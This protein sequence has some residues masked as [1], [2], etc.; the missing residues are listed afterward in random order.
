MI[1]ITGGAGFIGSHL[2]DHLLQVSDQDILLFDDLSAGS[3]SNVEHL[4]GEPR[5]EVVVGDVRD[6]E[7]VTPLVSEADTVY[8]LA[9]AVGVKRI[10]ENPLTSLQTNLFGTENVLRAAAKEG[11]RTFVAS[12]S[13]VYGKSDSVP[14]VE[15]DD[16]ILGSTAIPRWGYGMAKA[17][18]EFL[19]FAYHDRHDLPV[20]IGRFF[21]V[22]GPRQ[23]GEYGMVIP[24][25]VE[26]A[27]ADDPITVYGDGQQTR[28]FVDARDA[29]EAVHKLV[30][31]DSTNGD[32]Y[33]IGREDP[34]SIEDL[35]RLIIDKG[36][37][38]S[39]IDYM[40]LEAVYGANFEE[41]TD[42]YPD[43]SLLKSAI[44]WEPSHSLEDIVDSVI[45]EAR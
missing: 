24:R 16:L 4:S 39:E 23:T 40:P 2:A 35:A 17:L 31:T 11:T 37:S 19:A 14:F 3:Q 43:T 41:P 26:Q 45:T 33:N 12:S 21:N 5:V 18:D 36:N 15:D 32:V 13:E 28:S 7:V 44:N 9:A 42:R 10:V 30:V 20:T 1:L 34:I 38:D 25:F 6:H 22:V 8:H 29:V 27:L